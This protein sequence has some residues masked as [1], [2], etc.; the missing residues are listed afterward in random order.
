M[1]DLAT[2]LSDASGYRVGDENAIHQ[3]FLAFSRQRGNQLYS[4]LF[5]ERWRARD[6]EHSFTL[7]SDLMQ[8]CCVPSH[9]IST[10]TYLEIACFLYDSHS[11]AVDIAGAKAHTESFQ[12]IHES[13]FCLD[14]LGQCCFF[15]APERR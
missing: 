10:V 4:D 9:L 1:R 12:N 7:I 11:K 2:F 13:L 5:V 6:P 14:N 15:R 3:L 8:D